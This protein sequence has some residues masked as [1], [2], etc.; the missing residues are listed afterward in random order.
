MKI[1]VDTNVLVR[2]VMRDDEKQA[3]AATEILKNAELIAVALPT[4]CEFVWVLRKVYRLERLDIASAVKALLNA[5]NLVV[6]RPAVE[7]GMS[8]LEAGG[9]LPTALS[10]MRETGLLEKRLFHSIKR[11]LPCL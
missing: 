10:P 2:S 1:V 8:M 11:P 5:G 9:D 6:N 7:A 4:L 3:K